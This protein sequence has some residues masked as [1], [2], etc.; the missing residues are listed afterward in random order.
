MH[1]L[2]CF[3][4]VQCLKV[5]AQIQY[6]YLPIDVLDFDDFRDFRVDLDLVECRADD[7]DKLFWLSDFRTWSNDFCCTMFLF[8]LDL[9]SMALSMI[10]FVDFVSHSISPSAAPAIVSCNANWVSCSN[11]RMSLNSRPWY[12]SC[13]HQACRWAL[14][15]VLRNPKTNLYM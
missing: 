13:Q 4:W 2:I 1:K 8:G 7:G 3:C 15:I 10:L 14:S 12:S 9:L 5:P 11:R 6:H